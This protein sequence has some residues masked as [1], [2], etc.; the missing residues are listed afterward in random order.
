[1]RSLVHVG[2]RPSRNAKLSFG[3]QL[4]LV[5]FWIVYALF[6]A[7]TDSPT[8]DRNFLNYVFLVLALGYLIYILAQN[9]SIFGTQAYFEITPDYIV[10]KQGHFR[11]KIVIPFQDVAALHL[12]TFAL[13]LTMK[14][15]EHYLLDLKLVRR[16]R[17]LKLIKEALRNMALKFDFDLTET[18]ANH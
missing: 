12:A 9:T 13:K 5:F 8:N 11:K 15:G 16:R 14:N 1:M 2:L 18:T 10:Q 7:F 4:M 17:N 6:L 3:M